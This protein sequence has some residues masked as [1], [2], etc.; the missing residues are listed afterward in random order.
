MKKLL[1][2]CDDQCF[3]L[4]V[5]EIEICFALLISKCFCTSHIGLGQLTLG[6]Q[7]SLDS[8][9]VNAGD[10]NF[11]SLQHSAQL[12]NAFV[13]GVGDFDQGYIQ[14][15]V[16]IHFFQLANQLFVQFAILLVY[17]EDELLFVALV[18]RRNVITFAFEHIAQFVS[19]G[20]SIT[21]FGVQE[22]L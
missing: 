3:E 14:K 8:D 12:F 1:F 21:V 5:Q 4:A 10:V 15:F 13:T 16:S 20:L 11:V 18:S 9:V 7:T 22:N 19:N 17:D 6:E 2:L